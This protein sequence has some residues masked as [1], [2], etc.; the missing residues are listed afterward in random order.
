MNWLQGSCF[1]LDEITGIADT[2]IVDT[3]Y[4]EVR[5]T[6]G[7]DN[8]YLSSILYTLFLPLVVSC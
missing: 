4:R 2:G 6:I 7:L 1:R 8:Y 3:G 5:C